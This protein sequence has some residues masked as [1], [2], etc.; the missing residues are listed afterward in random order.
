[1]YDFSS[2]KTD[3]SK[4]EELLK[5]Y[6]PNFSL[7][8][9]SKGTIHR[10]NKTLLEINCDNISIETPN[11]SSELN[12]S[13]RSITDAMLESKGLTEANINLSKQIMKLVD[14]KFENKLNYD[15]LNRNNSQTESIH[16]VNSFCEEKVRV[17]ILG[18][19]VKIQPDIIEG[20]KKAISEEDDKEKIKKLSE[21]FELYGMFIPLGFTLGGKYDIL[22]D[23][24]NIDEN[25]EKL[26]KFK[27]SSSFF[28]CEQKADFQH[29]NNKINKTNTKNEDINKNIIKEGGDTNSKTVEDWKK[30]LTLNNLEIVGYSNLQ[31]IY[32]FCGDDI[33]KEIENLQE[34]LLEEENKIKQENEVRLLNILNDNPPDIEIAIGILGDRQTGKTSIMNRIKNKEFAQNAIDSVDLYK[35]MTIDNE[36]KLIKVKFNDIEF[37]SNLIRKCDG[38]ILVYDINNKNSLDKIKE[39]KKEID[40]KSLEN[41]PIL[42]LGNKSDLE[43]KVNEKEGKELSRKL[44]IEF[45]KETSCKN[46]N[47][48]NFEYN[49]NYIIDKTVKV[50]NENLNQNKKINLEKKQDKEKK[51]RLFINLSIIFILKIKKYILIS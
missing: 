51:K 14:L 1:M 16:F 21:L 45:G 44:D 39:L 7:K 32:K 35:N 20:F 3:K 36:N 50:Y 26:N 42:L 4:K 5:L 22:L 46:L 37:I 15:K 31:S 41:Q 6:T 28:A 19:D 49:I 8:I 17:S 27:N 13:S 34:R 30:S 2:I 48:K 29:E 12:S 9:D 43:R 11:K 25:K 47:D 18:K 23:A 33:A 24:K 38:F 40:E 10:I